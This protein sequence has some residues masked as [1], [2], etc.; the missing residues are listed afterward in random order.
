MPM[1]RANAYEIDL[2]RNPANYAPLTPLTFVER[3]ASVY[4][5]RTAVHHGGPL[6]IDRGRALDE[7]ERR[8]RRVIGRIAVQVDFVGV[9]TVHGHPGSDQSIRVNLPQLEARPNRARLARVPADVAHQMLVPQGLPSVVAIGNVFT[10]HRQPLG[11]S[12][13]ALRDDNLR[14]PAELLAQLE[15]SGDPAQ[16]LEGSARADDR[17][18]AVV[19]DA[20]HQALVNVQTLHL[21]EVHLDRVARYESALHDNSPVGQDQFSGLSPDDRGQYHG[22]AD[23]QRYRNHSKRRAGMVS[24]GDVSAQRSQQEEAADEVILTSSAAS[25]C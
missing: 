19:K 15:R 20:A 25:S 18:V 24:G 9:G 14:D 1:D 5:E 12:R 4:P 23:H 7:G 17:D 13:I 16:R 10:E 8:Q 2:D 22:E 3:A 11:A 21:V 6:G